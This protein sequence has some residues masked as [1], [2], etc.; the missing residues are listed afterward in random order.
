MEYFHETFIPA[1]GY[2]V[3]FGYGGVAVYGVI[4]LLVEGDL[5]Y[6]FRPRR[7]RDMTRAD[8]K[9]YRREW[10]SLKKEHREQLRAD[11]VSRAQ[12]DFKEHIRKKRKE[13]CHP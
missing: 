13:P 3:M 10:K 5:F 8:W 2:V 4:S 11:I 12:G 7:L 1:L 9:I 6:I